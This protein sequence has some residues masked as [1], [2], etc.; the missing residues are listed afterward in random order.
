MVKQVSSHGPVGLAKIRGGRNTPPH[1]M[2]DETGMQSGDLE[3]TMANARISLS[4]SKASATLR[5]AQPV[6]C[7]HGPSFAAA[8]PPPVEVHA[9]QLTA[10][11]QQLPTQV[12]HCAARH[13]AELTPWQK[14]SPLMWQ[15]PGG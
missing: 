14:L 10:P 9:H 15:P 11:E 5:H 2:S 1:G 6:L 13:H 7:S 8:D 12:L 4:L 3:T